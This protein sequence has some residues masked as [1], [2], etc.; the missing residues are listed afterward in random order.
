MSSPTLGI[1]IGGTKIAA[2]LLQDG[3]LLERREAPTPTHDLQVLLDAVS[4]L[5]QPLLSR[6]QGIG[7]C[8]PGYLDPH[9]GRISFAGNLPALNGVQLEEALAARL[10]HSVVAA[11]DADAATLAEFRLGAGCELDSIFYLTVS[12]GIGGGHVGPGGL[13]RGHAG[14]AAEVGHLCVEPGGRPCRCG[15]RG[16]LEAIASGTAIGER[17]SQLYGRQVD[18]ARVFSDWD[19]RN[20][21]AEQ[22]VEEAASALGR[23]LAAVCQLLD[24]A[25]LV[26]GGSVASRNPR[27]VELVAERLAALLHNRPLPAVLPAALAGDA[28]VI[29]AA[30]LPG[31]PL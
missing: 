5:L 13:L 14:A 4:G 21:Q 10:G 2:G 24:P 8:A 20:P 6:A 31:G 29:G 25:G 1:D 16:C 17:A 18:A 26:L 22:V 11:N 9:S 7:V 12:T 28:G 3:Q 19:A 15:G 30:L 23:G 27:F